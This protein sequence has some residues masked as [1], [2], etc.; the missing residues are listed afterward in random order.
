MIS[1]S[2][3]ITSM[4]YLKIGKSGGRD[5]L[6]ICRGYW[7]PVAKRSRTKTIESLGYLDKLSSQYSDP[8]SHFKAVVAQ[9][10]AEAEKEQAFFSLK[11]DLSTRLSHGEGHRKNLGYAALSLIY[12]SLSLDKFFSNRSRSWECEYSLNEIMKLLVFSR[13]LAPGSKKATYAQKGMYFEKM[14]FT[15]EDLYRCL[16][17]VTSLEKAIQ[18][19][20]HTKMTELYGRSSELVYYDVT[21]YY[22]E[23]DEQ[24][25][26]RRKGVSKEHRPDPIIQMG[27]FSDSRGIPIAYSLYPGN[28]NDAKTLIPLIG[29]M[30]KNYGISRTILVADK[31]LNTGDNIAFNILA[32]N[33]Y[34]LSQSVRGGDK[35]LKSYVLDQGG[36]K[37]LHE[38]FKSKSRLYPREIWVTGKE[39]KKTKV[40]VDEKQVA[41]YSAKYAAKAK[42][43]RSIVVQKAHQLIADPSKY[44]RATSHGATRYVKNLVFDEKTGEIISSG[45]KPVFDEKKLREEEKFDGYYVVV[46]SELDKSDQ[47]ILDI[48]K[49][50]WQIEEA[51]RVS[52]SDLETRPVYLSREDRIR[53]HFLIC[54]ISL[55]IARLL[56]VLLDNKYSVSKIASSLNAMSVSY[57]S[58][59]LYLGD[60]ADEITSDLKEKFNIDLDRKFI[61]LGEIRKILGATK[62]RNYPLGN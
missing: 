48:Y 54:F 40:V 50:L 43:D 24:D 8:I 32:G 15:L 34:V 5:Y 35:N 59:N 25:E 57:I 14:D 49:G 30:K 6:S 10:N 46:T 45:T 20:L 62:Q 52:K 16:S 19:H 55:V 1:D 39:G 58:E 61:T 7:D 4:L 47:E 28:T 37:S 56:A 33:G 42:A 27:L 29:E 38:G 23:I 31:G 21:N 2:G 60:Y 22:F 18:L 11:A 53:A 36:Y 17:R 44:T 41:I 3:R 26:M 12:H 13:I 51:F 9:M